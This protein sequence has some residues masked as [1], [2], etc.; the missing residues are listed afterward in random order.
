MIRAFFIFL[1]SCFS[2]WFLSGCQTPSSSY[3]V[4]GVVPE[5]MR[6]QYGQ[7]YGGIM[8]GRPAPT[9][10]SNIGF[11]YRQPNGWTDDNPRSFRIWNQA[12]NLSGRCWLDGREVL[13]TAWGQ[14]PQAPI[15]T[16]SGIK[17]SPVIPPGSNAFF[18]AGIGYHYLKC[19]LYAGPAP[20]Q[21]AYEMDLSFQTNSEGGRTFHLRPDF[22]PM[23]PVQ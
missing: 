7:R 9:P 18:I 6:G 21:L 5:M 10:P 19:Q 13:P 2:V 11:L 17:M 12:E 16:A 14:V 22:S 23:H 8:F 4:S 1:F 15:A 3:R 20:L